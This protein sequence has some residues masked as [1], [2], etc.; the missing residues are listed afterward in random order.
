[1]ELHE[2]AR[3][4]PNQAGPQR[5]RRA[6]YWLDKGRGWRRVIKNNLGSVGWFSGGGI[7]DGHLRLTA[8]E[9]E[10][11]L[12]DV[13]VDPYGEFG[14]LMLPNGNAICALPRAAETCPYPP[15]GMP[16][17]AAAHPGPSLKQAG[18]ATAAPEVDETASAVNPSMKNAPAMPQRRLIRTAEDAEAVAADWMRWMGF[19][20]AER[21]P[22][23]AD[24]GIDVISSDAV[25]QVKMR[26]KPVGSPDLQRLHGAALGRQA[27][28][29]SLESYTGQALR[30]A[31]SAGMALFRFDFQGEPVAV[32]QAAKDLMPSVV[33]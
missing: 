24:G 7:L 25:A 3:R 9:M 8:A 30:W 12:R 19:V 20:D 4:I 6:W 29:F 15:I 16:R 26:A 27:L 32:N 11:V 2:P 18:A 21:T 28:F 14:P 22:T 17:S 5:G 10:Q 31:N 33:A 13:G 23:G 1:V